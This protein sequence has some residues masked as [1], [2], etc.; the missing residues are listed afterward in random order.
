MPAPRSAAFAS[1]GLVLPATARA[2]AVAEP[3]PT[4]LD[5]YLHLTAR[6]IEAVGIAIIVLG[7]VAA[8][9]YF[10]WQAA[11]RGEPAAAYHRYRANLGRGILLGLEFLVAADII[12]TVA[13]D[14]TLR[15]LAVLAG[16]VVI[17]TFL[18]FA[19]EIEIEGRW[20]WRRGEPGDGS[21][22]GR[23]SG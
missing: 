20:P 10:V 6:G 3:E 12:G 15:N 14:P 5:G 13:V 16:I 18:S 19:L 1:L 7:A 23:P 9:L 22:P 11:V 4:W 21:T 8:T 2:Q 17:R